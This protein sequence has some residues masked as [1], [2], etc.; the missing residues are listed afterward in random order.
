MTSTSNVDT[1]KT[2][3]SS[4]SFLAWWITDP[5]EVE[6]Q[7]AGYNTLRVWQSARGTASLLCLLSVVVTGLLGS[8]LHLS[9]EEIVAEMILWSTVAIFM[10]RG[11]RWAFILG[12]ALWTLEKAASVF[13][14]V[15]SGRT[16]IVQII[17]WA[18]YMN[19]FFMG[20]KVESRR[21]AVARASAR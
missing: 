14:G 13:G 11:H 5:A 19:A 16:P 18:I 15:S 17:W 2:K 3:K 8:Y 10:Y 21:L 12:M 1:P 4:F 20:F 6:K 9:N 7:V